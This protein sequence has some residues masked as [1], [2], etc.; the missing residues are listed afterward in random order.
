M[1]DLLSPSMPQEM[2]PL[3]GNEDFLWAGKPKEGLM[4]RK[5]D[6]LA[7]PVS[8]VFLGMALRPYWD[9][10]GRTMNPVEMAALA[11]FATLG[12]YLLVGRF[13]VDAYVR[14]DM[15]Y[16]LTS[17]RA[18]IIGGFFSRKVLSIDLRTLQQMALTQRRDGLGTI[19]FGP[20]GGLNS[21]LAGGFWIGGVWIDLMGWL[22]QKPQDGR[23]GHFDRDEDPPPPEPA[24]FEAVPD[25]A[26]V[27]AKIQ[28]AQAALAAPPEAPNVSS[29]GITPA[30]HLPR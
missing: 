30:W 4:F 28:Q 2:A 6:W 20:D 29:P 13:F 12:I 23:P 5:S 14:R 24:R 11:I 26:M 3:L 19:T 22:R 8:L 25:A 18:L 1:S 10:R 15:V 17:H 9:A 16:G 7:I 21:L 27:M